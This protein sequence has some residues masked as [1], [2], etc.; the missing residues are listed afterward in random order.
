MRSVTVI[1]ATISRYTSTAINS[2]TKRRVAAYARVSTEQEEQQSSYE[3]QVDYYTNYIKGRE[4]WEFAGI[5]S[6]EG[7]TGTS[8]TRREGFKQMVNDALSGCIDL[9]ITKSVSRFARNTVDSL[10]TIRQ[11]KEKGVEVYFEKEN[12]W[13]FDPK[14]EILLTIISSLSQEE[15]RSISENVL[16]GLRKKMSDGKFSMAY[17][18]FLGYDK[19]EDGTLVVNEEQA[20]VVR[21]IYRLYLEGLTTHTIAKKLTAEGIKSPMGKDKWSQSTV[22]SILSNEKYKGDALL[23]KTYTEDFLSKKIKFNDGKVPQYYV[24]NSHEGIVSPEVFEMVQKEK[25]KRRRCKHR[26]SGVDIFSSKIKCGDCGNYYGA[27]VWHSN[28]KYRRVVYQCNSKFKEKCGTPHF[29]EEEIKS[30]FVTAVNK[31]FSNKKELIA[32]MELIRKKLSDIKDLEDKRLSLHSEITVLVEMM[33][34]MINKNARVAQDQTEYQKRYDELTLKYDKANAEF[35]KTEKQIAERRARYEVLG[36]FI[37]TIK[38][39]SDTIIEFDDNLWGSL[40]DCIT[41]HS[42]DNVVF[43]FK[44]GTE[45]RV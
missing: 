12:I 20:V 16:W 38:E 5:Y 45:I 41:V 3:A 32:N 17:S 31:L 19:G 26:Y 14:V 6:D 25:E 27:K 35:I 40:L 7:V 33:Q 10:T 36:H 23:Q 11:L 28:S 34:S 2:V 21:R 44:D 39:Q 30:M 43:T 1:P 37:K 22:L 18:S 8:T 4:D 42:K 9:I 13:T 24:E 15:S 29:Y